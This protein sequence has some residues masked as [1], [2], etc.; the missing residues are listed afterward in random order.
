MFLSRSRY[1]HQ[2]NTTFIPNYKMFD[3][4]HLKFDHLSYLK[5]LYKQSQI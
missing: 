5:K 1:T 3:F 4:F 2:I